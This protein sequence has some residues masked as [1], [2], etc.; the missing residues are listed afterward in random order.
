MRVH[1]YDKTK[2][3][4]DVSSLELCLTEHQHTC[5]TKKKRDSC[6]LPS[7]HTPA[8]KAP[9]VQYML[10]SPLLILALNVVLMTVTN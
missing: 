1:N 5:H 3:I 9:Q 2:N 7:H 4:N 10:G 6:H 8:E